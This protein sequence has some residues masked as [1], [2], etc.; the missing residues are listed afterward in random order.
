MVHGV[1]NESGFNT[2]LDGG[3]YDGPIHHIPLSFIKLS[4]H[5]APKP[6][7]E[8]A[9]SGKREPPGSEKQNS[10]ADDSLFT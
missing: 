1:E 9:D 6:A 5:H 10:G 4:S 3:N 8:E 2:C 7:P